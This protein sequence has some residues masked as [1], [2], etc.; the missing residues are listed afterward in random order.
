MP[1]LRERRLKARGKVAT[2]VSPASHY[3][4][5]EDYHQQYIEKNQ[6]H[7]FSIR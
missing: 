2:E 3:W 6:R 5:A 4:P 1:K 7:R